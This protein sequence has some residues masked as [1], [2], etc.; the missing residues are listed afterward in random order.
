MSNQTIKNGTILAGA[1]LTANQFYFVKLDSNGNAVLAG[2]GNSAI[3]VLQ[4][5]PNIGEACE[6]IQYGET[7]VVV[8]VQL[9]PGDP[10]GSSAAG[11]AAKLVYGTDTAKYV[12]GRAKEVSGSSPTANQ[13]TRIFVDCAAPHRAV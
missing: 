7:E 5:T 11:K 12:L 1:D 13:R 4:N 9:A 2:D 6:L 8:G 3:G 10:I